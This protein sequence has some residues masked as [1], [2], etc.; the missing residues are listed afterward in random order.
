MCRRSVAFLTFR[1]PS[2]KRESI[3]V[4]HDAGLNG[5]IGDRTGTRGPSCSSPGE[6][7]VRGTLL[8]TS[9]VPCACQNVGRLVNAP[10]ASNAS[11]PNGEALGM[12]EGKHH[13]GGAHS[14]PGQALEDEKVGGGTTSSKG[15]GSDYQ[16]RKLDLIAAGPHLTAFNVINTS[17]D[18]VRAVHS[19]ASLTGVKLTSGPKCSRRVSS[20]PGQRNLTDS[21]LGDEYAPRTE[22]SLDFFVGG[23]PEG[24]FGEDVCRASSV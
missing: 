23:G 10:E 14:G 7:D 16:H 24:C 15:Y 3:N 13:R 19:R 22:E 18:R 21:A 20:F 6:V 2:I 17:I 8:T 4:L 11:I 9:N 5:D 1:D 12:T